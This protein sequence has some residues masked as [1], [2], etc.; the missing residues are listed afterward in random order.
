M[1]GLEIESRKKVSERWDI[2]MNEKERA[3]KSTI[4]RPRERDD[5]KTKQAVDRDDIKPRKVR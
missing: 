3:R 1:T 4:R 2:N 5:I